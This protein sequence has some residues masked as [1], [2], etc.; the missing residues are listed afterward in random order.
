MRR[1]R[2]SVIFVAF[3]DPGP[4]V[5]LGFSLLESVPCVFGGW[6]HL[7]TLNIPKCKKITWSIITVGPLVLVSISPCRCADAMR[8]RAWHCGPGGQ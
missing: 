2:R 5:G 4:P 6:V 1:A 7:D 8:A 3:L